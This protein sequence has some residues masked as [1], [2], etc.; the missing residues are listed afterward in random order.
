[1]KAA[2]LKSFGSPLAIENA[3]DP[4]LGTGE[5]IV[6]VVATRVLS[7]MNEVFDGTRNYALDLPII[8]GPGGIGRVRAI[9]PDAT[10]LSVGDWVFCDPT[11]RSRDDVVAP[12]IALQGLT[13]AGPGGMRLQQH[14][15]HGSFAE[16]MRVPTENVK[17]LGAITS[18]D[19]TRWC[20]LG[21]LLVPYGGF[22]AANLQPGE[23]VLVS[24][25][26]GNFGSAAVS[27]ALAMGA[28]CVVTP[29]RNEKILADLVRR[30]GSRVL[31]VRLT[32]N[33]DHD[34]EAMKRAAPSPIDCV[35]DIMPPSVS[36]TVVRAAIMTVRPYGRVAL[37]GGV[38]MAGGAGL[39]L[40]YPWIM[41]NCIS[42]HGVWMYPP[43]AA[44]RLIAL[45]RAGLLRLDEYDA[46]AFD[47]DHANEAV[48]HAAANGGPFKLT[49]IRP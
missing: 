42:I 27:V 37:M 28:A 6:D 12:D 11:V 24:G 40:P 13:A 29:G 4:V 35:L 1:M 38:G 25:A 44:S 5:V 41:R 10:K 36:P 17:R 43:D 30:F 49:V 7:Y 9:G 23:T 22:L 19:A 3:P 2:V 39:E 47:L 32:G 8:P 20:A 31:P 14:F 46:T 33:E 45:V 21:T 34:R 48:A 26:T 15:R 16:Q 18:E